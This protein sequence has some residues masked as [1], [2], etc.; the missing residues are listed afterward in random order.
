MLG[1]PCS[2][3]DDGERLIL[4]EPSGRISTQPA[5][6]CFAA[7]IARATS[8][9]VMRAAVLLIGSTGRGA[10]GFRRIA[11]IAAM[12]AIGAIRIVLLKATTV[13][14]RSG[15]AAFASAVGAFVIIVEI[16]VIVVVRVCHHHFP[17][18]GAGRGMKWVGTR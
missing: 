13:N 1:C 12:R 11:M 7:R 9:W 8:A 18:G 15:H 4:I 5:P 17:I 6:V 16:V 3:V 14:A 2:P 10:A